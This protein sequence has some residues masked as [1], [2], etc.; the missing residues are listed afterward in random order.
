MAKENVGRFYRELW[1]NESL[2]KKIIEAQEK[3]DGDIND[4][5]A[6]VNEVVIPVA[7]ESGYDFTA[8]EVLEEER[9]K[10]EEHNISEDELENVSG[11][12]SLCAII[13]IGTKAY[14]EGLC[15]VYGMSRVEGENERGLGINFCSFLGFGAGV[16]W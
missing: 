2:Q 14:S 4:R 3:Y 16:I 12:V 13:G 9:A 5:N 15:A 7:K 11:G 10:M 6:I 8:E 1:K